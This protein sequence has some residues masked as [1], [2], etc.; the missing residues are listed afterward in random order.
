MKQNTALQP[1][2]GFKHFTTH[3]CVTGSLRHIYEHAGFPISEE[4]LLGLGEGVGFIYWHMKG[5]LPFIGGRANTGR[6]NEEGMEKAAARCTGVTAEEFRTTSARK[7]ETAL[8]G[9]LQ[10]Q[11]PVF[12]ILDMGYLPYFDF[13]GDDFHFGY[14]VVAACGYDAQTRQVLLADRDEELH[15]VSLETLARARASQHKPFPPRHGWYSFDFSRMHAPKPEEILASIHANAGRMVD[16]PISNLG[17]KGIRKAAQRIHK[18][19]EVLSE[20]DLRSTSI[21]TAFMIDARGGTGGGLFRYMYG[22]FL[23]EATEL[24]GKS[25]FGNIATQM[26]AIAALWDECAGLFEAA[27]TADEP[28]RPLADVCTL[29]PQIADMEEHA[30]GQLLALSDGGAPAL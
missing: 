25:E 12:L 27:Y 24:I 17:V 4:M 7:A 10:A 30:W 21:Y 9:Q 16:P 5:V 2:P 28:A 6:P 22:R 19:P 18:W 29:L 26:K 1:F 13:G 14:H 3:H 15:P 11:T 8:L 20:A 23:E